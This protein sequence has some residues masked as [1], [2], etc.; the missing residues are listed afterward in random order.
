LC[1]IQ[2]LLIKWKDKPDYERIFAVYMMIN[3]SCIQTIKT[4]FKTQ[5][6]K[7]TQFKTGHKRSTHIINIK[8]Y[9]S[10]HLSQC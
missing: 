5:E 3:K 1:S 6:S 10:W 9:I 7:T 2:I 4:T 8:E